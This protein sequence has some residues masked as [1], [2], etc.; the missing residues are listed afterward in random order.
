ML[1]SEFKILILMFVCSKFYYAWL[2]HSTREAC[3]RIE[4]KRRQ[5]EKRERDGWSEWGVGSQD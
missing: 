3:A 4:S 2:S 1:V 5:W